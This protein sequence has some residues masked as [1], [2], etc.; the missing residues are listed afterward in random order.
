ML[1]S[2]LYQRVRLCL[3]SILGFSDRLLNRLFTS[4][5]NPFYRSGTLAVAF[6]II[7]TVTGVLLLFV[8]RVGTPY[9]SVAF[10]Q[11]HP[12]LIGWLRSMH[13][14]SSDL[15]LIAVVLHALR[16]FVQRKS[17]GAR[18]LAWTSGA[19]LLGLLFITGWT[20]FVMVWGFEGQMLA[21][22]FTRMIDATALLSTP[23]SQAFS[24]TEAEPPGAFFFLLLFVHGVLPLALLFGLWVHTSRM[25]RASWFPP[26]KVSYALVGI[27]LVVSLLIPA[28][29]DE[30][31]NL[32]VSPEE[33][34]LNFFYNPWL[35]FTRSMPLLTIVSLGAGFSFLLLLP[36][37]LSPLKEERPPKS[38]LDQLQCN[39]CV[40]CVLDCPYEAI[41]M[42]PRTEGS[43][44][45]SEMV[46]E[47]EAELCVSCGLCSASCARMTIGPPARKGSDQYL[48][49]KSLVQ[50]Y[51]TEGEELN[52]QTIVIACTNQIRS[53]ERLRNLLYHR[54]DVQIYPVA[55]MGSLHMVTIGHLA[56]Y[57]Q[58]LI[59]AA[60]PERNCTNKDAYMLLRDRLTGQR[61][62][63]LP[64]RV[65]RSREKGKKTG[66]LMSLMGSQAVAKPTRTTPGRRQTSKQ[67]SSINSTP[68]HGSSAS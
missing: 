45:L 52:S 51:E 21:Q 41:S 6:L 10:L 35:P 63:G 44:K 27:L 34:T 68:I 18:I 48:A 32:F 31:A 56:Y 23:I 50:R 58:N 14:Y 11:E 38:D 49:V 62:P 61:L 40:Q 7:A 43:L 29:L 60:C 57:F 13:R 47:V 53:S 64:G 19:L 39:G 5:Y 1:S 65:D 55:C 33:F 59:L 8:Y 17:W 66:S 9:E 25:A 15:M 22:A 20:G 36:W 24:G 2:K 67:R 4:D 46:A 28:S 54:L 3:D 26:M 42:V 30:K 16:M 37:F 12:L